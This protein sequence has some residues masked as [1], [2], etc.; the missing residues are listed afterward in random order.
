MWCVSEAA[1]SERGARCGLESS[2]GCA[3]LGSEGAGG[4][5]ERG[6]PEGLC[7][8]SVAD[9]T[10]GSTVAGGVWVGWGCEGAGEGSARG[11][12]DE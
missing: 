7:E 8:S 2:C 1:G 11:G 10:G 9:V 4:C 3:V 6:A 12:W 5:W